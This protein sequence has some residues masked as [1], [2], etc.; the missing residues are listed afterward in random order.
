MHADYSEIKIKNPYAFLILDFIAQMR[1]YEKMFPGGKYHDNDHY[2]SMYIDSIIG[3]KFL[4]LLY[5]YY[6]FTASFF[7]PRKTKRKFAI[8]NSL[9]DEKFPGLNEIINEICEE[10]N[11]I[12]ITQGT[13]FK[14]IF[15][16]LLL[17]K[18]SPY[19][20]FIGF[21]TRKLINKLRLVDKE[22]WE[23]FLSDK[24]FMNKL[25]SLVKKDV[26]RTAKLLNKLGLNLF[27]NTGDSSGQARVLIESN[28]HFQSKTIS[29]AHGYFKENT[30]IGVAPVR[31]DIL[32]SWTEDQ[33][34]SLIEVLE[35]DSEDK[36]QTVG[37][38]KNLR[39]SIKNDNNIT[40]LI[41]VGVMK[42]LMKSEDYRRR[43][44]DIIFELQKISETIKI[45]LHP[46]EIQGVDIIDKF[47]RSNNIEV[48]H[49]SLKDDVANSNFILGANTSTLVEAASTGKRV[50]YL[51][52]IAKENLFYEGVLPLKTKEIVNL[53][54]QYGYG[55]S[56]NDISFNRDFTKK[57]LKDVIMKLYPSDL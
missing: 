33:R 46:H 39:S 43:F 27:I 36:I 28:N 30:L 47:M 52:Q 45:R 24:D 3:S 8:H 6:L 21:Q 56:N 34:R 20:C 9:T 55:M 23:E 7:L 31:S 38:P 19:A 50:Y 41:L 57:R 29:F 42:D 17:K 54:P 11:W 18:I 25:D 35:K 22:S 49:D 53:V 4:S 26:L 32:I 15:N 1:T 51:N 12:L 48:S 16:Y 2:Y 13:G 40:A 10:E 44:Q 37:F 5:R 14:N